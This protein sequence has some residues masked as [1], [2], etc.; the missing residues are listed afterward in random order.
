MRLGIVILFQIEEI[1]FLLVV[2][3]GFIKENVWLKVKRFYFQ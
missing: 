2:L 3:L 1:S